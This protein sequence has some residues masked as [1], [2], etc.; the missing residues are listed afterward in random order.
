MA[1]DLRAARFR[2]R[3]HCV[4]AAHA[5]RPLVGPP[6]GRGL[7]L[8]RRSRDHR[9]RV[10]A[11]PR[12]RHRATNA[13]RCG[14]GGR[15]SARHE[16]RRRVVSRRPR[17]RDRCFGRRAD[18]GLRAPPSRSL[19]GSGRVVAARARHRGGRR[20]RWSASGPARSSRRPVR[21]TGAPVQLAGGATHPRQPRRVARESWLPRP[22]V[23]TVRHV[24][25]VGRVR[26]GERTGPH[27]WRS[28]RERRACARHVRGD[29]Q[30]CLGV[31][32][33][34]E[35]RRSLGP[36]AD[37]EHRDDAVG[38]VRAGRGPGVR[39]SSRA[40]GPSAPRL[41]HHR[42]RGFGAVLSRGE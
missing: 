18:A 2:R 3:G 27:P 14:F 35:V 29:R 15:V 24:D 33:R 38:R 13:H 17:T 31:L 7:R 16:D 6:A 36:H 1:H 9:R 30:R 37:H 19:G 26:R 12:S 22:H 39:A 41:G 42:G 11:K 8:P 28:D 32:A 23:G 25:V 40:F 21:G 10:R 34:W 5:L 4:G 20:V